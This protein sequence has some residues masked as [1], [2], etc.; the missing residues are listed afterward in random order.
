MRKVA[1]LVMAVAISTLSAAGFD[2]HAEQVPTPLQQARDGV[3][4]NEI[5]CGDGR[6]LMASPSGSPACVF[7]GST[8]TLE[9]RGFVLVPES[10]RDTTPSKQTDA[11]GKPEVRSTNTENPGSRPFVT[12]WRTTVPN[13]SITIPVGG[14]T[15]AYTVDWGDGSSVSSN[16]AG[17][18]SHAYE[19]AGEYTVRISGDFT[20]I[21]LG[22]DYDNAGKLVSI[23]QWGD[24]RWESMAS[25]FGGTT[26]TYRAT[27]APDLSG[28]TDM[29][30]MFQQSS[31]DGDVSGWDV[32]N[33]EIMEEMFFGASS[34]NGD[35]SGWDVSSVV[36]NFVS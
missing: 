23:D 9:Q 24:I 22:E 2:A 36:H 4:L 10:P 25:A 18:Q 15:G 28:V 33:V 1:I 34:F 6:V 35:V 17:D 30:A 8:T 20:R 5:T 27:D 13:E 26:F 21:L 31:F 14:T 3:P 7:A 11:S 32:S 12:T 16:V 19:N 29:S